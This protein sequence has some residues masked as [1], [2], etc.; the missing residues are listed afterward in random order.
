MVFHLYFQTS[1]LHSS[2]HGSAF[3]A[4]ACLSPSRHALTWQMF[5]WAPVRSQTLFYELGQGREQNRQSP[6]F[7]RVYILA[8]GLVGEEEKTE[9]KVI[10][11]V[12]KS[13]RGGVRSARV[14]GWDF[15]RQ[16]RKASLR[17]SKVS[18]GVGHSNTR[19]T[20]RC[21]QR[22]SLVWNL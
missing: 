15:R 6:L 3:T 2:H 4:L 11:A 1:L 20:E 7:H 8:F 14:G 13:K 10:N 5:T 21:R 17:R 19:W 18:E 9:N 12:E 16:W 22:E